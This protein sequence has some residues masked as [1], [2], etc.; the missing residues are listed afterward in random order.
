MFSI[1]VS[2]ILMKRP[3]KNNLNNY[4]VGQAYTWHGRYAAGTGGDIGY[5]A[6]IIMGQ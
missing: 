2:K 6:V 5:M 1:I 4:E 3:I